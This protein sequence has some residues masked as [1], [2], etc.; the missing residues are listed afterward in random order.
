MP[1]SGRSTRTFL[2]DANV[3]VAA[4]KDP[5]RET[6]TLKFLLR[7]IERDGEELVTHRKRTNSPL[8]P[9]PSNQDLGLER[10][11][12]SPRPARRPPSEPLRFDIHYPS[13]ATEERLPTS[14]PRVTEGLIP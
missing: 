7:L 8:Q 14:I 2:L 5:R 9:Y 3:L 10:L 13:V 12:E 11:E 4:V 6:A 1:A